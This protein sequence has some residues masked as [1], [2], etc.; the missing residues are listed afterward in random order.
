MHRLPP[1]SRRGF[2]RAL[3]LSGLAVLATPHFAPVARAQQRITYFTWAGYDLPEFHQAYNSRYGGE[4]G[5]AYFGDSE[6]AFQK[7]RQGFTPPT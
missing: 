1:I 7:L 2:N 3:L 4:P 6:E 5:Y